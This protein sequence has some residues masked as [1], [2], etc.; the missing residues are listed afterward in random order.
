MV[1]PRRLLRVVLF[2]GAA[3][4]VVAAA[5][6]LK[7]TRATDVQT[8]QAI[9]DQLNSLDPVTRA[10]VIARL[11]ADAKADITSHPRSSQT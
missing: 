6:Q 1:E 11:G 9:E 4:A 7:Q 3:A 10:A 8:A 5:V 2:T